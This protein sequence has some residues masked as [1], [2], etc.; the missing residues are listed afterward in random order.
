M[1]ETIKRLKGMEHAQWSREQFEKLRAEQLAE[2]GGRLRLDVE[3]KRRERVIEAGFVHPEI[4]SAVRDLIVADTI[5]LATDGRPWPLRGAI[6]INI[7]HAPSGR[8]PAGQSEGASREPEV[9]APV[10]RVL[11]AADFKLVHS[12]V[13]VIDGTWDDHTDQPALPAPE[14]EQA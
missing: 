2:M 3:M 10:R 8:L 11:T 6:T 9:M 4:V 14:K 1:T 12:V 5:S 13:P 7:D